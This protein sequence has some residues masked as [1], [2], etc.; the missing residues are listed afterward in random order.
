VVPRRRSSAFLVAE[1]GNRSVHFQCSNG[2]EHFDR[3]RAGLYTAHLTVTTDAGNSFQAT[4]PIA[5]QDEALVV[6]ILKD[7]S[8]SLTGQLAAGNADGALALFDDFGQ[9]KFAGV[10]ADLG[11]SLPL[12]LA[13]VSQLEVRQ[14]G[15]D[16]AEGWVI[17]G[18]SGDQKLFFVYFLRGADGV[19]RI[20]SL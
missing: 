9:S 5:V 20:H 4:V 6:G 1:G 19:W 12:A 16:V 18:S 14:V 15:Q 10:F 8:T 11:I 7:L 13:S 17:D 2:E 3:R